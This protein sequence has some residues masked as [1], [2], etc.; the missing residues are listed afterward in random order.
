MNDLTLTITDLK[1]KVEKLVG[2]HGQLKNDNEKLSAENAELHKTIEDQKAQI[3]A[4][5]SS[6]RDLI[7]NKNEEQ[8][9][10]ITDTKEKINELVQEIDNCIAL[11]K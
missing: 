10:I 3:A 5:E 2:L 7:E 6:S 9:T 8:N 11:L 4:L 1:S